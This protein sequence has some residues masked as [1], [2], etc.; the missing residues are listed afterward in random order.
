MEDAFM[1]HRQP[2]L[3]NWICCVGLSFER[4]RVLTHTRHLSKLRPRDRE[5]SWSA[6][7]SFSAAP[8]SHGGRQAESAVHAS[9]RES[10]VVDAGLRRASL[11]PQSDAGALAWL[12]TVSLRLRYPRKSVSLNDEVVHHQRPV[13][14]EVQQRIRRVQSATQSNAG[15]HDEAL[16]QFGHA[17]HVVAVVSQGGILDGGVT[18]RYTPR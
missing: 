2:T 3:E 17:A 11:P 6:V 18:R 1:G 15:C 13:A 7:T 14:A 12:P 4:Y 5:A 10:G 9:S 8:L 16:R